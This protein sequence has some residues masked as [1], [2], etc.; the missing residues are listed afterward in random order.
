MPTKQKGNKMPKL[1]EA[2]EKI[3]FIK[4]WLGIIVGVF[5]ALAGWVANRFITSESILLVLVCIIS[6]GLV[7]IFISLLRKADRILKEIKELKK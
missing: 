2:K 1:D 4:F 7:I 3:G 5:T 6:L